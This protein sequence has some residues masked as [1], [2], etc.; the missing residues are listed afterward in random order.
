MGRVVITGMGVVSPV[1]SRLDSFWDNLIAGK[2][3]IGPITKFNPA[4]V[5]AKIAGQVKDFNPSEFVSPKEQRRVDEFAL[6]ALAASKM[7]LAD[8]G[9]DL[10]K[11]DPTMSGCIVGSGVG[12]LQTLEHQ[13]TILMQKG[14]DRCSPFM[15]PQMISNMAA[16]LIGI[17]HGLQGPNYSVVSACASAAHSLGDA[18]RLIQR[19]D[20]TMMM[21][22][23]A[24]A[25]VCELGI[26]GFCALR[27]L[28]TRNDEPTRASRPFDRERDGFVMGDGSAILILE[29]LDHA[30]KR[31]ARIYCEFVGYGMTCDAHHMTAPQEG[32]AGAARA[33]TMAMKEARLAP[34]AFQY[35]NAHGTSTELND[36]TETAAIKG[37]MGDYARKVSISST[38][39][40]TGHLL[41]AAAGIEAIVCALAI[42]KG[43]VPPTI[44]YE[45]PDPN[46][47]LDYVP[48]QARELKVDATL[49]NSLGFGGHNACLAFRKFA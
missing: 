19:G 23:G 21:A 29:D 44:N 47:D 42:H 32:G 2:S 24:E 43:V 28:S 16:G 34:E 26:A 40:M 12:G 4:N 46:C 1:G 11:E 33:M 7:A 39:S 45:N 6:F 41:G 27:A 5:A 17:E 25:S 38:K 13:H 3:G 18:L 30:L 22:G 8:S 36:K 48:N 20:A 35:V 14:A 37:A 10:S 9:I 31:N 49:N 15:I